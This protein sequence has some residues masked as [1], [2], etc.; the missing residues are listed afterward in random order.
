[1]FNFSPLE[2]ALPTAPQNTGNPFAS[3]LLGAVDSGSRG[4]TRISPTVLYYYHGLFLQD[5]IKWSRKLTL[6]LGLRWEVYA[7]WKDKGDNLSIMDPHTPNPG[8]GGCPGAMIFA[9]FG[10]GR[11][12]RRRLTPPI[13]KDNF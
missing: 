8:C 2:T 11:V 10:P 13:V 4:I 6:N 7:P 9:G 5:D 3:F 12:G 1:G